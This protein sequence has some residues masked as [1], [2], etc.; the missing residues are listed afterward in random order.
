MEKRIEAKKFGEVM[1]R[2]R[3]LH[4]DVMSE[5]NPPTGD[6][7]WGQ[8]HEADI[9]F[10][11]DAHVDS[12]QL[13]LD[14]LASLGLQ[15]IVL[16]RKV[17]ENSFDNF[18]MP[19]KGSDMTTSYKS[20]LTE[21]MKCLVKLEY[22][23]PDPDGMTNRM[24]QVMRQRIKTA[25]N[26]HPATMSALLQDQALFDSAWSA[27]FGKVVVKMDNYLPTDCPWSI[28]EMIEG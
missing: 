19:K 3:A 10:K 28:D 7:G 22:G 27:V 4:I 9:R 2:T 6:H 18:A 12:D 15:D 21:L 14:A 20:N 1:E 26:D 13:M 11:E 24:V 23:N 16:S 8:P 25:R 17:D 5:R